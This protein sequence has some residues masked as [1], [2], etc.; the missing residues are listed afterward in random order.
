MKHNQQ[1]F[2]LVELLVVVLIIGILSAVAV[3]MYQ[4][5][6]DKSRW[7]TLLT[8]A[9]ALQTAQT[10]AYMEN[11]AYAED[12]SALVLSLPGEAQD[13]KYIMP[14]AEYSIDTKSAN[15]STITGQLDTLP[16]VRLSMALKNPESYLFCE[17][18]SGDARAERL[19]K[20]L[21]AGQKAGS[22]NGY[23]K[24][25]LD[26][27]GTCAWANT[28]G[29]CYVSEEARCSAMG[30]PYANGYCGYTE[31]Q[32]R[33]INEGGICTGTVEQG[34]ARSVINEGGLCK[35]DGHNACGWST[36]NLGGKC[37]GT[38][39]GGCNFSVFNAGE[40][41]GNSTSGAACIYNTFNEGAICN[42][43]V[44][45]NCNS[46]TFNGGKCIANNSNTCW[47]S[48]YTNG[49]CCEDYGKGY[50]PADAPK[51]SD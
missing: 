6:I 37:T 42:G 20:N 14:D 47:G 25:I 5:A 43:N 24:Y 16:N 2:T 33:D 17:A 38:V 46:N 13:N 41:N 1:A 31:E 30:M 4:G 9:K 44:G 22:K 27:P 49:G 45:G 35:G 8:P 50:C 29:Q 40:C 21:L 3:P 51:C 23:D 39:Y 19:C 11:G 28:T 48:T 15:Q 36:F 10:A 34:C 7:S 18:K 12:T 26:Y 32:R